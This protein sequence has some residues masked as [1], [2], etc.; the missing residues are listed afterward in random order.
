MPGQEVSP[1][2]DDKAF[3]Y[4]SAKVTEKFVGGLEELGQQ[5]L[6]PC[7]LPIACHVN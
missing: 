3:G 2:E 1:L 6:G 4:R 5:I 7:L